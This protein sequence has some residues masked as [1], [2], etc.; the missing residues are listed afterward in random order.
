MD[1]RGY[2]ADQPNQQRLLV[3]GDAVVWLVSCGSKGAELCGYGPLDRDHLLSDLEVGPPAASL[4]FSVPAALGVTLGHPT[5]R[6]DGSVLLQ[7]GEAALLGIGPAGDLVGPIPVAVPVEEACRVTFLAADPIDLNRT[8]VGCEQAILAVDSAGTVLVRH[9]L[10]QSEIQLLGARPQ[11]GVIAAYGDQIVV[12][13]GDQVVETDVLPGIPSAVSSHPVAGLVVVTGADCDPSCAPSPPDPVDA[14]APHSH[15]FTVSR[16]DWDG[17][18]TGFG[19]A[20]I[21]TG[22]HASVHV[23]LLADGR[24]IAS[25]PWR[26]IVP[27]NGDAVESPIVMVDTDGTLVD[28]DVTPA[29]RV[30]CTDDLVSGWDG[31]L[32]LTS[33]DQLARLRRWAVD[34]FGTFMDDDRSPFENEIEEIFA[35]GVTQGCHPTGLL[36]CPDRRLTRAQLASLLARWLGLGL[37]APDRFA[38]DAG[39]VHEQAINALARAGITLGCDTADA[40]LFCPQNPVSRGQIASFLAR[41]AKLSLAAPDRFADDDGSVHEPAINALAAAGI[42]QGCD[43]AD[44]SRYCPSQPVPRDQTAALLSRAGPPPTG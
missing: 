7:M 43:A 38:D 35:A 30:C 9:D 44:P 6:A 37:D 13:D 11:G 4:A 25:L 21:G 34:P 28:W 17:R 20:V 18:P 23:T 31:V 5:L 32:E 36:F 41:A 24:V 22:D 26:Q 10:A 1:P 33:I 42:T 27:G 12:I 15:E 16:L 39:S 19:A 2:D 29:G 14:N 40:A 3:S 8:W